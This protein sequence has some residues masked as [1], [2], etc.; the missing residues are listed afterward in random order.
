MTVFWR[1][2]KKRIGARPLR[3]A[4]RRF[5]SQLS[6][7]LRT[8]R[9]AGSTELSNHKGIIAAA[10]TGRAARKGKTIIVCLRQVPINEADFYSGKLQ[11]DPGRGFRFGAL[12]R[13]LGRNATRQVGSQLPS[14]EIGHHVASLSSA[15][16][17]DAHHCHS[18]SLWPA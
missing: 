6:P 14:I 3:R 17:M 1:P 13:K 16:H 7:V 11:K 4:A 15:P 8:R 18:L 2:G 12:K 9:Y 5:S 10:S